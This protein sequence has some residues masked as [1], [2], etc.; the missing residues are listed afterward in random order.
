MSSAE[1]VYKVDQK[2]RII[3]CAITFFVVIVLYIALA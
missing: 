2:H 3:T 1:M